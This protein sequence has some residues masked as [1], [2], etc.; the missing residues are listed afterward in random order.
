MDIRYKKTA[1]MAFFLLALQLVFGQE[2]V[3]KTVEKSFALSNTGEFQITNEYGDINIMGWAQNKVLVKVS[4]RVNHRKKENAEDLLNRIYPE[5]KSGSNL[6][7]VES[8]IRNKNTGWLADFFNKNNPID[9]DR[10]HVQI[11]Y[12]VFLPSKAKLK[13]INSF[14][15]VI[16][17]GWNSNLDA[18]V[19]HGDLWIGDHL[20]KADIG[21]KFGKIHARDLDYATI[22]LQNGELEMQNSKSLRLH[23]DGS[24]MNIDTVNT[25]EIDSNKD[26][27][28]I[29][30]VG[31]IY[32]NL[33]FTTLRVENL[34]K[35]ADL[36]MRIADFQVGQ[37]SNPMSEITIEEESS[38]ITLSIVDF[39]HRFNATLEEGVVRL[40]KSFE[41]VH[42]NML[43]KGRRLR[44]INATYGA[45]KKGF[46]SIRGAKGIVT[47]RD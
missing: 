23:G 44:E 46:I 32:G 6:I 27:I 42:S 34:S 7:H 33:K 4:I 20:N 10:S 28:G 39:S 21:L 2:R 25:L 24:E 11:D 15:D 43:D 35:D 30:K 45:G 22:N 3:S 13:T 36:Q 29:R 37:I 47:L 8:V 9:F 17:E 14:G 18:V 5:F 31:N 1:L 38:E 40:P 16:I 19:E 26:V 12:E 41:N